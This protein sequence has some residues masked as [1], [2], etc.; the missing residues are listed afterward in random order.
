MWYNAKRACKSPL[1]LQVPAVKGLT[2]S[3]G[4]HKKC[5]LV[6]N[7]LKLE[8]EDVRISFLF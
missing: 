7:W 4:K 8:N 2:I 3:Y 6:K 1:A 5:N